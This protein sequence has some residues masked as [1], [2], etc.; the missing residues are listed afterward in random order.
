MWALLQGDTNCQ[1]GSPV[2]GIGQCIHVVAGILVGVH[3]GSSREST[4]L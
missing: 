2:N 3:N 4:T 1:H